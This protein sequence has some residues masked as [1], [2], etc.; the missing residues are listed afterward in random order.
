MENKNQNHQEIM[1]FHVQE[2]NSGRAVIIHADSLEEA[3]K[4]SKN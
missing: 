3:V 4:R 2:Q 1:K